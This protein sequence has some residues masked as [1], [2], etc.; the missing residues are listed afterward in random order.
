MATPWTAGRQALLSMEFSRQEYWA[1]WAAVP[2]PGNL[3]NPGVEPTFLA[4][5]ALAGGFFTTSITWEALLIGEEMGSLLNR[6]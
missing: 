2:P 4:S 3:P 1:E 6:F 5:P